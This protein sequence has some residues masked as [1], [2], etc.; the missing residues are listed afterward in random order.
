MYRWNSIKENEDMAWKRRKEN[1][2]PAHTSFYQV[3]PYQA[4]HIL[5]EWMSERS[6]ARACV[7]VFK[8]QQNFHIHIKF[9]LVKTDENIEKT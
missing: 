3:K 6:R 1:E 9:D 2:L 8:I 4:V 5:S 7:C